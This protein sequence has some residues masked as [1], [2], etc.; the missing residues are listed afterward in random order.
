MSEPD[1]IAILA[2]LGINGATSVT[3]VSGGWE[4]TIWKVELATEAYALRLLRPGEATMAHREAQTMQAASSAGAAT[5]EIHVQGVWQDRPV[6]LLSWCAGRTLMDEM[7]ARPW[8]I[9]RLGHAFGQQQARLNQTPFALDDV[10]DDGWITRFSSVDDRLRER[11]R[12][13]ALQSGRLLHLD[14]HPLNVMVSERKISCV[15]DWT[16]AMPGDPR[17]DVAR[18]WSI[19]RLMPLTPGRPEPVT[20]AARRLLAAGWLRGYERVAGPLRDMPLFKI[21]A[22]LA[23][24]ND[25]APKIGQPG[26]WL[27]QRHLDE[28]ET[29]VNRFRVQAGC[30]K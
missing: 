19:L 14:Y 18:T 23:M 8:A 17:A 4:T 21:W 3:S 1:P 16:N 2:K 11:L 5:P 12:A 6:M 13:A 7:R 26:I 27:E 25:L 10:E 24:L 30:L 29:R 9:R 22:G 15:L 28:I 20:E